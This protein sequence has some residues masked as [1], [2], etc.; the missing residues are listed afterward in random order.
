LASTAELGLA[1]SFAVSEA[2]SAASLLSRSAA[3]GSVGGAG[4]AL[5][6]GAAEDDG[7]CQA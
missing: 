4:A 1:L 6:G 2:C 5:V 3:L 7:A